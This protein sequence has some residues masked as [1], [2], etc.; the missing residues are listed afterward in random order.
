MNR[1]K[2]LIQIAYVDF[3]GHRKDVT[4]PISDIE[5]ENK[6][7]KPKILGSHCVQKST[8]ELFR[9]NLRFG[10]VLDED[11]YKILYKF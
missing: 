10:I 1:E 11:L 4:L 9:I 7:H 2:E 3:W 8:D 5:M 6:T